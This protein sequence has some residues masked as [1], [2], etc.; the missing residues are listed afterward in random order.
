VILEDDK[1]DTPNPEAAAVSALVNAS[2]DFAFELSKPIDLSNY[3]AWYNVKAGCYVD[4]ELPLSLKS[5][6]EGL[7]ASTLVHDH[8]HSRY[9]SPKPLHNQIS[10]Y[11]SNRNTQRTLE[12][13]RPYTLPKP[14]D[15]DSRGESEENVS[16]LEMD[17][18]L[19]FEKQEKLSSATAPSSTR[20]HCHSTEQS[21][22]RID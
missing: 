14:L 19:A 6:Q 18:L 4:K 3:E 10:Q 11:N 20:P 13:L 8:S 2:A 16:K 1:P 17:M 21:H 7:A 5:E 22:P 12:E 9:H 15:E